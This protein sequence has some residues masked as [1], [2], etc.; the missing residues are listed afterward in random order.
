MTITHR[1][2]LNDSGDAGVTGYAWDL[3]VVPV[4]ITSPDGCLEVGNRH[5]A[6]TI[7]T[8]KR[9]HRNETKTKSTNKHVIHASLQRQKWECVGNN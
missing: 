9:K 5:Q 6:K 4:V 7:T 3:L 1:H 8:L 2:L